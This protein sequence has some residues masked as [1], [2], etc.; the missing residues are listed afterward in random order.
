MLIVTSLSRL[1]QD[2]VCAEFD[3]KRLFSLYVCE[4]QI[5]VCKHGNLEHMKYLEEAADVIL[6]LFF[7]R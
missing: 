1:I 7:A 5:L 2:E 3:S 6:I 4:K